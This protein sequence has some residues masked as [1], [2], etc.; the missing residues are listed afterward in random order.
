VADRPSP[1][2][3]RAAIFLH[4]ACRDAV[5][6]LYDHDDLDGLAIATQAEELRL[7][8]AHFLAEAATTFTPTPTGAA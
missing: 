5:A 8:L 7:L 2:Q 3:L 1:E 6:V 4:T